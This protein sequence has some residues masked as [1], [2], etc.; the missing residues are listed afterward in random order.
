MAAARAARGV[1]ARRTLI[2]QKKRRCYGGENAPSPH[3][4]SQQQPK[5]GAP[6]LLNNDMDCWLREDARALA[7][8]DNAPPRCV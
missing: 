2:L 8:G 4:E 6:L 1:L 3:Y 7:G 5:R